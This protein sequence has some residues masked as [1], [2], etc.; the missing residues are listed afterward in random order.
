MKT[1][2]FSMSLNGEFSVTLHSLRYL[3]DVYSKK[4]DTFEEIVIGKNGGIP[5]GSLEKFKEADLVIF[6]TSMYH[7]FI[8][9][10]AMKTMEEIGAYMQKECPDKPITY[11]MTSNFLMDNLVHDYIRIWARNYGMKYIKGISF[12]SDDIVEEKYRADL[13]AWFNNVKYLASDEPAKAFHE[14]D[15]KVVLL[16]DTPETAAIAKQ[17]H[18]AFEKAGSKVTDIELYKYE[19]K[20]C[21]GCQFCY[22]SRKCCI[23]DQF[24]QLCRDI[25]I[26]TDAVVYVGTIE[27]GYYPVK[28]KCYMDRHVCMGRCPLDDEQIAIYSFREGKSFAAGDESILKTWCTACTSFGGEILIDVCKEFNEDA[29]K[30][31]IAAFN[32]NVGPYRDFYGNALKTRFAELARVIRNVEPLDYKY[33]ESKGAYIQQPVNDKCCAITNMEVAKKSVEMKSMPVRI[34]RTQGGDMDV[35]IPER[36]TATD[37]SKSLIER[38]IDPAYAKNDKEETKTEKKGFKLFGKK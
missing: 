22:T 38:A 26:G 35:P 6:A 15:T 17:Y 23:E 21:M 27:N 29:V 4:G 16:D 12:F 13:Y 7:F 18:E 31:A 20:H 11:F 14:M 9:S 25:D 19:V 33:F 32:F 8:A 3:S 30:S 24:N 28:F 34:Y 1:L 5:E 10:Q 2:V 36:R 37:K